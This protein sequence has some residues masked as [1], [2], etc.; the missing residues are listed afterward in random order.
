MMK[1]QKAERKSLIE[2]NKLMQSATVVRR[3]FVKALLDAGGISISA[4]VLG[5]GVP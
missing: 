3:D 2:N 1:E 4:G 5:C